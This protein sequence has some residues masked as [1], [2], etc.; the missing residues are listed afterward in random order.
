MTRVASSE[1]SELKSN[2]TL[3]DLEPLSQA[4]KDAGKIFDNFAT[5]SNRRLKGEGYDA[6]R[7]VASFVATSFDKIAT[8]DLNAHDNIIDGTDKL[9]GF[10]GEYSKL[11]D[12]NLE[13]LGNGLRYTGTQIGM[14]ESRIRKGEYEGDELNSA[15]RQLEYWRSAYNEILKEY[16]KLR[17]LA[18]MNSSTGSCIESISSDI[19]S[20]RTILVDNWH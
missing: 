20:L 9:I 11:D 4:L 5:Y 2:K 10:M 18:G 7:V 15:Y 12:K 14:V 16:E 8:L 1:L 19:A 17:D 3:N 6:I 13:H